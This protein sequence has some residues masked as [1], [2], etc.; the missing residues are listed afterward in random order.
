MKRN[1]APMPN[2]ARAWFI[3][4]AAA[5]SREVI[6]VERFFIEFTAR[7]FRKAFQYRSLRNHRLLCLGPMRRLREFIF[8]GQ[9][10]PHAYD[11]NATP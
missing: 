7:P 4:I 9:I 3:P 11:E 8:E 5:V 6:P 10:R 1:M 2:D